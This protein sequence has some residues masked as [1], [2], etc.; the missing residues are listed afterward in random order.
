MQ[1]GDMTSLKKGYLFC[2]ALPSLEALGCRRS[3]FVSTLSLYK[4]C[5]TETRVTK[6]ST[7][8]QHANLDEDISALVDELQ[9][10]QCATPPLIAGKKFNCTF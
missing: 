6:Q 5:G 10:K 3:W 4:V 7:C 8:R 9:V 1:I 2:T